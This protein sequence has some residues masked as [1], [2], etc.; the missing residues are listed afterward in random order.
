[1][2]RHGATL[3]HLFDRPYRPGAAYG[4]RISPVRRWGMLLVL[5]LLV[6]VIF[7]YWYVTD[8]T[9]TPGGFFTPFG[10]S[11][12][13]VVGGNGF[14]ATIVDNG[15]NDTDPRIGRMAIILPDAGAYSV[16]QTVAPINHQKAN[17]SCKRVDVQKGTPAW[18]EY[19]INYPI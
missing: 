6:A 1:M 17:P 5:L 2:A 12:F 13:E 15:A 3:D 18:L 4:P 10:P 8:G 16:C 19:F 7:A 9:V 11:T 14:T